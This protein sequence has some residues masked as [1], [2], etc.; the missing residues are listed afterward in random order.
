MNQINLNFIISESFFFIFQVDKNNSELKRNFIS[1]LQ[2]SEETCRFKLMDLNKIN[3]DDEIKSISKFLTT[4]RIHFDY[5][6]R[7][8]EKDYKLKTYF[9]AFHLINKF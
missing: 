5:L 8:T 6:L 1:I 4:N 9:E 3:S 7:P 2:C